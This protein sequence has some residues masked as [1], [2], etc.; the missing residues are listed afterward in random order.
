MTIVAEIYH[1]TQRWE[2]LGF[3]IETDE[4]GVWRL[5]IFHQRLYFVEGVEGCAFWSAIT[6]TRLRKGAERSG[7]LYPRSFQL[8]YPLSLLLFPRPNKWPYFTSTQVLRFTFSFTASARAY[9]LLILPLSADSP[10]QAPRKIRCYES[11]SL[12]S[13]YSHVITPEV[14]RWRDNAAKKAKK[15][16]EKKKKG[17]V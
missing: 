13:L 12:L 10:C 2:E 8:G 17:G 6:M 5:W 11:P 16:E 3:F 9:C 1:C 14:L 4:F 7:S 15:K